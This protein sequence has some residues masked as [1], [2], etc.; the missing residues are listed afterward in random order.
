MIEI[1]RHSGGD[2]DDETSSREEFPM[3]SDVALIVTAI[4]G[5]FVFFAAVLA[6]GDRTWRT[7]R[8]DDGLQ[9]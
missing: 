9:G 3:P 5:L 8:E 7:S 4:T 6:Y 1:K 2:P